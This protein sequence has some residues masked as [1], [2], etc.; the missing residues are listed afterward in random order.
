[1]IIVLIIIMSNGKSINKCL[2]LSIISAHLWG[3]D[4]LSL[5]PAVAVI[6]PRFS[7]A[8]ST[9][10][11][12]RDH[13]CDHYPD[14]HRHCCFTW[15]H[16]WDRWDLHSRTDFSDHCDSSAIKSIVIIMIIL[17]VL[18]NVCDRHHI[19]I[20]SRPPLMAAISCYYCIHQ[21]VH[22]L[23][24]YK[25][26]Y[27]ESNNVLQCIIQCCWHETSQCEV[28]R[29]P[30][31]LV[32][33]AQWKNLFKLTLT[34]WDHCKAYFGGQP[35]FP[36]FPTTPLQTPPSPFHLFEQSP[37]ERVFLTLGF[38]IKQK[39][40]NKYTHMLFSRCSHHKILVRNSQNQLNFGN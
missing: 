14:H 13:D 28:E 25:M 30:C 4:S 17:I 22:N 21:V 6:V 34:K 10:H 26:Y 18:I 19:V 9:D 12:L 20:K 1:M 38:S 16:L 2:L 7:T 39:A 23:V 27:N 36:S 40:I 3:S 32:G 8:S 15:D 5:S 11:H 33:R 35:S 29:R 31:G 24:S 37:F